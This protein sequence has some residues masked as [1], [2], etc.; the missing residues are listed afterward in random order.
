[1]DL[2]WHY[3]VSRGSYLSGVFPKSARLGGYLLLS[4]VGNSCVGN[5]RREIFCN[6]RCS[7][8]VSYLGADSSPGFLSLSRRVATASSKGKV[9]NYCHMRLSVRTYAGNV[10]DRMKN[11]QPAAILFIL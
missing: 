4:L 7:C 3:R 10:C 2:A 5:Y 9:P 1:M 11:M 8:I 6:N